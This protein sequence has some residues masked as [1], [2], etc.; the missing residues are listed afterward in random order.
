[1]KILY[2]C[3]E[4]SNRNGWGVINY[5]TVNEAVKA[6]HEVFV[7]SEQN[8]KNDFISDKVKNFPILSSP[9]HISQ[10][11]ISFVKI[12]L[13]IR[14]ILKQEKFDIVHILVEPYIAYFSLL[15]IENLYFTLVGT[16]S[17]SILKG[18]IKGFFY[19]LGLKKV[20]KFFSISD[21]TKNQFQINFSTKKEITVVPLGV[22]FK[23]FNVDYNQSLKDALSFCLIGQ[24]KARKGVIV[25]IRAI[26]RL[27]VNYPEVKLYIAGDLNGSYA[28]DCLSLVKD[29]N[30]QNNIIF[31][32][33]IG[34]QGVRDLYQKCIANVLPSVNAEDG[35][36]EGFGLIHL[37]A[38]ACYLPTIGSKNC[39]NESA[40]REGINGFLIDQNND[41]ELANKMKL[42]I[43]LKLNSGYYTFAKKC[44]QY[45]SSQG[46][47]NYFNSILKSYGTSGEIS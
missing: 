37:E 20:Q 6:G 33:Y 18:Y 46:W 12:V 15:K 27:K 8:A 21:Y 30:L 36:F 45:A 14:I 3:N 26:E 7:L 5:H 35:A 9:G 44:Y 4:L 23:V 25:A 22:D 2:V 38:N 19:R 42:I 29:K 47:D 28:Q 39:G 32:G 13:E 17:L 1:M 43:E 11:K 10:D 24:V 40:I 16:Y 34:Q 41:L 31:L